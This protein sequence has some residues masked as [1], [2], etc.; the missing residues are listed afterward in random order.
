MGETGQVVVIDSC[1]F[2][3]ELIEKADWVPSELYE[4]LAEIRAWQRA[5]IVVA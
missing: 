1:D 5:A 3:R 4:K 2:G